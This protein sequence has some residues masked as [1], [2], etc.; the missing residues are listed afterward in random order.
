MLKGGFINV[1]EAED[2]NLRKW[3]IFLYNAVDF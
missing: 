1:S 3:C 2:T